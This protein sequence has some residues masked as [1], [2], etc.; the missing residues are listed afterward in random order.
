MALTK[1][2]IEKMVSILILFDVAAYFKLTFANQ[3]KF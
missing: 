2:R 1:S 3:E